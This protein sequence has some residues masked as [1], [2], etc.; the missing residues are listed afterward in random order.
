MTERQRRP[1]RASTMR[2]TAD[3]RQQLAVAAQLLAGI[4]TAV[5]L[6]FLSASVLPVS[7]NRIVR[8]ALV[9]LAVSALIYLACRF[10]EPARAYGRTVFVATAIVV[11][12]VFVAYYG[13]QALFG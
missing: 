7:T 3:D 9:P 6:F 5:V 4:A 13:V 11:I 8:G 2:M 10:V 1:L 12:A